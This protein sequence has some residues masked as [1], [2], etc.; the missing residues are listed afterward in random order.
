MSLDPLSH[1]AFTMPGE[2]GFEK[3]TLRLAKQWGADTIRDSDGTQLSPEIL[4]SGHAIYSTVCLPRSVQPWAR[5]HGD[6]LQQN[7]LM[8]S[9]V[10]ATRTTVTITLLDGYF[11]EQFA[12]NSKDSAKRWWQ[13]F[14]RTAGR[15]VAK[16]AWSFNKRRGTVTVR[17]AKPGHRYTVNFLAFR[18]WEEISM[19]NHITNDWGDREHLAAVDP[20]QPAVQKVL[21]E[22]LERWLREH[23]ATSVVRFTSMFYNFS[24]FWGADHARLRDIYSDWGDYAMTISPRALALFEKKH[25]YRLTAED[26]VNGGLYNSTHNAPSRRYRDYMDFI[27]DFVIR[28]GRECIDLVHAHG[29]KAY[30]F[31][32][33][34]WVGVEPNSPRFKE[35]GFDGLIKCVFNAFEVR[36]CAHSKGVRTHELRLHP[37]LFPT[38]LKGEPTFKTGGNPTLDAKN[39]WIDARRG[40]VRAPIDRIGLGG[41]VSLVEP[42]PDFQNYIA[43]VANEFR[44]LKSF[45]AGDRPWTARFKVAVLTAWGDLRAWTCSG[46]F[47]KGV[48]LY[49]VL[50]SLA[51]L[52]L[53]VQFIS[54]DDLVAKGVP[55]GV[56]AIINCGR[57]GSAWSGGHYWAE[58]R[59]EATLTEFVRK[60]GGLV[61]VSEPSALAQPGQFFRMARVLGV[62]RDTGDRVANGKLKY[63]PPASR[64]AQHFITANVSGA[65]DLGTGVDGIFVLGGDTQVLAACEGS[66][67]LAT[68]NFGKGRSVYL[69]GFKFTHE[70]T[71]LLHRA[72]FWAASQ[73]AR[74]GAWQSSNVRTE[75]TCFAKAGKLVVIN[76]AGEP[77]ETTVTLGDGKA[78]RDVRLEAHGIAILDVK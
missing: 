18:L 72:L 14:D 51:G 39:F 20:M 25:G 3:L 62:D 2:A 52:P 30:V 17:G 29:K 74:W 68:H 36:L 67:R 21:L 19:Y 12:V 49:D 9:P 37:Y 75:A 5:A 76:N 16:R 10:V 26:F 71:R 31:Y 54:F 28:F 65:L 78:K 73:D 38:G 66:P 41:Y 24:W 22:F 27:H 13:V 57:A 77:Q 48:E 46:H 59:V 50:E 61:G 44:L 40:I 32:D 53:D 23:P 8:S 15:E 35:F 70:N 58:P 6:M 33:D 64:G 34:H 55:R 69:G 47:T 56:K 1:G 45:H 42:F 7:F 4:V 11:T 60:G 43:K 63:S